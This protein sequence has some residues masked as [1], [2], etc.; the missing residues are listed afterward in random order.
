[1]PTTVLENRKLIS[2]IGLYHGNTKCSVHHDSHVKK[3]I[4]VRKVV[5]MSLEA[6]G[7]D[8]LADESTPKYA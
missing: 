6:S 4:Q 2:H 8:M 3:L 1:M 7:P 5:Y